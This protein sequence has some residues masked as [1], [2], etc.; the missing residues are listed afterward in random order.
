MEWYY[1]KNGAQQGPVTEA[2]LKSM[3]ADGDLAAS[4]LV[5]RQGMADWQSYAAVFPEEVVVALSRSPIEDASCSG[6]RREARAALSGHWWPSVLMTFVYGLLQQL[7]MVVPFLGVLISWAITGPM[8]LGFHAFFQGLIRR[9][10]VEVGTLF[11]GFE[12][13]G[14]GLGLFLLTTLLIV[15]ASL[16]AMIPGGILLGYVFSES[17]RPEESPLFLVAL[18]VMLLPAVIAGN[19]MWLRYAMVYF[20]AN[21]HP[22]LGVLAVIRQSVERMRG[23]KWRLFVLSLSFIG[24]HIL[25]V[26]AL[27]FGLLW[28]T[29]YMFTAFAAFYDELRE[30]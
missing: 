10:R 7:A 29:V 1:E 19:Y 21:D 2:T 15:C 5:W 23:H 13:W 12:R 30:R 4:N 16:A 26:L 3:I 18:L 17:A 9:E 27:G 8:Q 11:K 6:L 14:Q 24:W 28:S 22:E 20:I 25:G